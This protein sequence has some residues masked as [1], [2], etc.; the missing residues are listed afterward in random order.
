MQE[1]NDE[2]AAKFKR[3]RSGSEPRLA[4][5]KLSK[6]FGLTEAQIRNVLKKMGVWDR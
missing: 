2:M 6:D 4:V 3:H 5:R 1:R